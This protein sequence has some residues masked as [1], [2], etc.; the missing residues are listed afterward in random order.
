MYTRYL[1]GLIFKL[2]G[3]KAILTQVIK[4]PKVHTC[5]I[6]SFSAVCLPL[7]N[8]VY[9]LVYLCRNIC[10]CSVVKCIAVTI[11]PFNWPT[12]DLALLPETTFT[13]AFTSWLYPKFFLS[14]C[15][16]QIAFTSTRADSFSGNIGWI[17]TVSA[18]RISW[19]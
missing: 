15:L 11:R 9:L 14:L 12:T 19:Y 7:L 5:T 4:P 17:Y 3:C 8:F 13:E 18:K 10:P 6:P 2:L 16:T 1:L